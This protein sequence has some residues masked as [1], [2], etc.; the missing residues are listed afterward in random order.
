MSEPDYQGCDNCH[1]WVK[2]G[3]CKPGEMQ[4]GKCRRVPPVLSEVV[5]KSLVKE[6]SGNVYA[7]AMTIDPWLHPITEAE[8][9]CGEW[10]LKP[11]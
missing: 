8:D 1:F 9:W 2:A 10:R 3:Y 4:M 7:N 11:S 6:G 5:L